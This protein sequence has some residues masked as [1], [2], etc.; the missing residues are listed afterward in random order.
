MSISLMNVVVV[1]VFETNFFSNF[2]PKADAKTQ[3]IKR[4]NH[5]RMVYK[6]IN[7][8]HFTKLTFPQ[9]K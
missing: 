6:I 7:S 9:I 4:R 8:M 1:L 3:S 5:Y 2:F